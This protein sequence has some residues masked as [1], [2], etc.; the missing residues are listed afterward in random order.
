[1]SGG[2]R[3]L[4][5][6]GAPLGATL[7]SFLLI[8][9]PAAPASAASLA[10]TRTDDPPPGA[11]LPDDCSLREAVL[12]ANGTAEHDTITLGAAKYDLERGALEVTGL[13]DIV[14]QGNGVTVIDGM[15]RSRVLDVALGAT[16]SVR[17]LVVTNGQAPSGDDLEEGGR[18]GA[19]RNLGGLTL[20]DVTVENSRS[21]HGVRSGNGFRLQ[22]PGAGGGIANSGTLNL[23]RVTVQHNSIPD[24]GAL[25]D[26]GTAPGGNGGGIWNEGLMTIVDS[27][28]QYNRAGKG[29]DGPN[30]D[31]IGYRGGRGG[32]GGGLYNGGKVQIVGTAFIGNEAG[33]GGR[34][35]RT[36]H[37]CPS[38]GGDGG[39]GGAIFHTDDAVAVERSRFNGNQAGDGGH[40]DL[41]E[42]GGATGRPGDG[43][44]VV[45][46]T[47]LFD[48]GASAMW[49]N[50]AGAEVAASA[51]SGDLT[52]GVVVEPG[53]AVQLRN[54]TVSGH[55][56][57]RSITNRGKLSIEYSTLTGN[58]PFVATG[59]T[60]M[61]LSLLDDPFEVASPG[62]RSAGYNVVILPGFPGEPTDASPAT[63]GLGPLLTSDP[64][65]THPLGGDST[66]LDFVPVVAC[67]GR[68]ARGV[69]RPQGS[70]CDAGAHERRLAP[71]V[72]LVDPAT[73]R[74]HL[75]NAQ[76]TV[77]SFFFGNPGDRPVAGDWD[78]DGTSTPGMYRQSD[79]FFYARHT[80]TQGIADA[81]CF[82]GNPED[83][84]LAGDWDG[85]GDANLGLYRPSTQTFHLY[86]RAC[87]LAPLGVAQISFVFGNPGDKPVAGDWDGDGADEV[88]LHRESTGFFYWR[89]SPTTGIADGQMFFGDPADRFV[90]GDWGLVDGVDTPAVFRPS[91]V[92][93]YLRHTLS[94]GNAD[95]QF[96]WPG[97]GAGW[98]PVAGRFGL[99]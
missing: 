52:G 19:I 35:G 98:L 40:G 96:P 97:A 26:R 11:C 22:R 63:A 41:P 47:G 87:G 65:P 36:C 55:A 95:S 70:G 67:G 79:G 1:M 37:S 29:G 77:T 81:A 89:N 38:K 69:H 56:P 94:Q 45:V 68:D 23:F 44:G 3:G 6:V 66:A 85:D 62:F 10:V 9:L 18:G 16:V 76:G 4:R 21:A 82:A 90:A 73:A 58:G 93:F 86:T 5:R 42:A 83:V 74:W 57:H 75:R 32:D 71:T 78:G 27:L 14:G 34:G 33:D 88:G 12:A 7:V 60:T 13:L 24:A 64:V 46:V 50:A 84:P 59:D 15:G 39:S 48:I 80:N 92:T 17:D 51:A 61:G 25:P 72:G 2:H 28:I 20:T 54:V 30:F 91:D 31:V 8:A 43:G 53:A 99:G 49:S